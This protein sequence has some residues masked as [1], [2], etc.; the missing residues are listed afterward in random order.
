MPFSRRLTLA[1]L[2]GSDAELALK[3]Q[4]GTVLREENSQLAAAKHKLEKDLAARNVE[5]SAAL[6]SAKDKEELNAKM[7]ALREAD[8]GS[9]RQLEDAV[10]MHKENAAK[11]QEKLKLSS[12]EITKGNSIISKLQSDQRALKDK[13]KLKVA[14]LLQQQEA[15][16]AKQAELDESERS[17]ASLRTTAAELT[18][19]K[20]RAEEQAVAAKQQLAEAQ[21]LLRSNQQ[22]IQWLNKELNEAQTGGRPYVNLPSRVAAFKPSLHPSIK[23]GSCA[24][25]YSP[26]AT[27]SSAAMY[28]H[29]PLSAA[30][31]SALAGAPMPSSLGSDAPMPGK[32]L[33]SLKSRAGMAM[34]EGAARDSTNATGGFAE[35]LTPAAPLS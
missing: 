16:E 7:T 30:G 29:S 1:G 4:E 28:D 19:A 5:L 9:K 18:A 33:S 10:S 11:L 35:Y 26:S 31:A 12:A 21:E 24:A 20:E 13:L 3:K 2:E 15:Q 6:Q 34:A 14:V 8:A 32:V 23:P 25:S 27:G 22:V 17:A